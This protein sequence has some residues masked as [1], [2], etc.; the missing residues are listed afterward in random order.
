MAEESLNPTTTQRCTT[1]A[2]PRVV[3]AGYGHLHWAT[4]KA[5]L[6]AHQQGQLTLCAVYQWPRLD[7]TLQNEE[8]AIL[9]QLLAGY[10]DTIPLLFPQG[11]SL[12]SHNETERLRVELNPD[13]LII[14]SWGEIFKAPWFQ[15][16]KGLPILNVHPSLLPAHRGPNPYAAA[17]LAGETQSGVTLHQLVEEVDAG[18]VIAQWPV[19]VTP[20]ETSISLREQIAYATYQLMQQ[21]WKIQAR[22]GGLASLQSLISPQPETGAS[23][24][25][26]HLV[27]QTL[28]NWASPL[29]VLHKQSRACIAWTLPRL[30]FNNRL[31]LTIKRL[32]VQPEANSTLPPMAW[33]HPPSGVVVYV[34]PDALYWRNIQL[35]LPRRMLHPL[36]R[37][38]KCFP[39]GW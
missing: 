24:H 18:D 13:V 16:L 5:T 31:E 12:Q 2:V 25:R 30:L 9:S 11:G 38:L 17:I 33:R 7:A 3:L 19:S 32:H 22:E 15:S 27:G 21:L 37:W 35:P 14:A 6:E 10:H 39:L 29:P 36:L 34:Q 1:Q 26:H 4:L 8:S 28:L 23:L 20:E